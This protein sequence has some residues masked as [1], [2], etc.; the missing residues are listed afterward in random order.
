MK[1]LIAVILFGCLLWIRF[2]MPF[3]VYRK[4]HE[5]KRDYGEI[6]INWII[7]MTGALILAGIL[8]KVKRKRH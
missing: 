3:P 5:E 6:D 8:M 2:T 4:G 1:I 7:I